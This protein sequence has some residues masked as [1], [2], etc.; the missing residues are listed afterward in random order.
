MSE[1]EFY[2]KKKFA[3]KKNHDLL[4]ADFITPN[5]LDAKPKDAKHQE[6]KQESNSNAVD[7]DKSEPFNLT[8]KDTDAAV[9]EFLEKIK[10]FQDRAWKK[11]PTK[12]KAKRRLVYGLKEVRKQLSLETVRCVILARDIDT[13]KSIELSTDVDMIKEVCASNHIDIL[14][15]SSKH[16]LAKVVKKWPIVSAVAILDYSGA[17]DAYNL[18][19]QTLANFTACCRI[20]DHVDQPSFSV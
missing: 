9:I 17:E 20:A 10:K 11:N 7:L 4:L 8:I 3:N 2:K 13:N 15:I 19:I 14:W 18:A 5:L 6:V 16:N 12:A 1:F